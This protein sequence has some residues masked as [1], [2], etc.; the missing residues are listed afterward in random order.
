VSLTAS[1]SAVSP[2]PKYINDAFANDAAH[3]NFLA[4]FAAQETRCTTCHIPGRQKGRG[5]LNDFGKA[6]AKHLDVKKFKSEHAAGNNAAALVIFKA[7]WDKAVLEQNAAGATF[8][9]LILRGEL[10]GQNPE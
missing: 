5:N 6:M 2:A 7:G 1:A 10:P 9:E 8:E 4:K 3:K